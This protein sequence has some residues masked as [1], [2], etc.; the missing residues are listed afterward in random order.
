MVYEWTGKCRSCQGSGF[1]S[2]Y[3]KRGKETVCKCIPCLGIGIVLPLPHLHCQKFKHIRMKLSTCIIFQKKLI[4][5]L[6][7]IC[8][9]CQFKIL[10][11]PVHVL[12]YLGR[13]WCIITQLA[14]EKVNLSNPFSAFWYSQFSSLLCKLSLLMIIIINYDQHKTTMW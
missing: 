7:L 12:V 8:C 1:V 9:A 11:F 2:Y 6:N 4:W 14:E 5:T 3:N 13:I 10:W